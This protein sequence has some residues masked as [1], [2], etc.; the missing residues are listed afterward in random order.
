[1][2]NIFTNKFREESEVPYNL[3]YRTELLKVENNI[4]IIRG[5]SYMSDM[6]VSNRHPIVQLLRHIYVDTNG[7]VGDQDSSAWERA[8]TLRSTLGFVSPNME[9]KPCIGQYIGGK[10]KEYVVMV[11]NSAWSRS[12]DWMGMRP[13]RLK[14][15]PYVSTILPNFNKTLKPPI[16]VDDDE[17]ASAFLTINPVILLHQYYGYL[18][19]KLELEEEGSPQHYVGSILL[20][21]I[22]ADFFNI[23]VLNIAGTRKVGFG[24]SDPMNKYPFG[25][26]P[27]AV[28]K[29]V[30]THELKNIP[31]RTL[32]GLV[33]YLPAVGG[34]METMS[35]Y[36]VPQYGR[37]R[38]WSFMAASRNMRNMLRIASDIIMLREKAL[39]AQYDIAYKRLRRG[40]LVPDPYLVLL[41][42]VLNLTQEKR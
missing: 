29:Y 18:N 5:R 37:Y 31:P 2:I 3:K 32:N 28:Y 42:D 26:L 20:P 1:M 36:D 35:L 8:L 13:L 7:D 40:R 11:N 16:F 12:K 10:L 15:H 21:S 25:F 4:S 9:M 23:G 14:S 22:T 39:W 6:Y 24:G 30:T 38:I 34:M 33:D 41:E 19:E 17:E 27:N